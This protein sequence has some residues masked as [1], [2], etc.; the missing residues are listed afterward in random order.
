MFRISKKNRKVLSMHLELLSYNKNYNS[1]NRKTAK[2]VIN[3][4][5]KQTIGGYYYFT[6][7][8]G[9]MVQ[10]LLKNVR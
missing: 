4:L 9:L 7:N 6:S 3:Y 1:A 10:S 2:Q 5:R 8:E